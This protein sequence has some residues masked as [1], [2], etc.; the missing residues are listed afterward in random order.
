V[1]GCGSRVPV[2]PSPPF[3]GTPYE[4]ALF[5]YRVVLPPGWRLSV[6][7]RVSHHSP[8]PPP[9]GTDFFT[10]RTVADEDQVVTS[11]A[12]TEPSHPA[13]AYTVMVQVIPNPERLDASTWIAR[14]S[15][16]DQVVPTTI[17][18]RAGVR[19]PAS[20]VGQAGGTGLVVARDDVMLLATPRLFYP[21]WIPPGWQESQL[22]SD[23][24]RIVDSFQLTR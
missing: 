2:V 3:G 22:I 10:V 7:P 20:R 1:V 14:R 11:M 6:H 17:S 15:G 8:G 9:S 19:V 12:M 21:G 4:S 5:G 13:F 16:L 23:A 18:G 24:Q